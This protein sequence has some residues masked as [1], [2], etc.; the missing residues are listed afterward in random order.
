VFSWHR[1]KFSRPL[2]RVPTE[3]RLLY[4]AMLRAET[5]E[6]SMVTRML[7]GNRALYASNRKLGGTLYPYSAV[8]L[9][10]DDWRSHYGDAW[11]R[12]VTAKHRY[13]P[14]NVFASGPDLF[15]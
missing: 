5:A 6:P 12:L 7:S 11:Q 9:T 13:D 3:G 14:G 8:A 15:R 2:C 4:V 1:K 10:R